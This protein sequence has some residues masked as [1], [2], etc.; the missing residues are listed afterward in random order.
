MTLASWVSGEGGR[1]GEA[2]VAVDATRYSGAGSQKP[3]RQSGHWRD[4]EP[5]LRA[6]QL[7]FD[8]ELT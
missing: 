1:C 8:G 7:T 6:P 4:W 2:G 5:A 3:G